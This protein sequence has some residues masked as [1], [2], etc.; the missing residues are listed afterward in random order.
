MKVRY[1]FATGL[2]AAGVVAAPLWNNAT[3]DDKPQ[4]DAAAEAKLDADK[5]KEE[6]KKYWLGIQLAATP[7]IL[8]RHVERLKDGGAMVAGVAPNS[9]AAKAGLQPGDHILKVNEAVVTSP[10][11]VVKVVHGSNGEAVVMRVLRGWEIDSYTV[12]PEIAPENPVIPQPGL[13][14]DAMMPPALNEGA[15]GARIRIFGPAQIVPPDVRLRM[16]DDDLPQNLLIRVEKKGD[17]PAKLH[18]ER[19]GQVWDVT[20]DDI[21]QLPE[22]LRPIAKR[23][24]AKNANGPVIFG[25]K[26]VPFSDLKD[27][28][29]EMQP[30][31]FAPGKVM[32]PPNVEMMQK[33]MQRQMQ[34]MQEMMKRMHQQMD[35]IQIQ[36]GQPPMEIGQPDEV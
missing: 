34:E 6:V 16:M 8:K 25:G 12:E 21:D 10:D 24:L 2:L 4:L 3:A 19:E 20:A 13:G 14:M 32:M 17:A 11:D 1:L 29:I 26:D 7:E 9:P 22:D 35:R 36:Q 18:I 31:H 30:G 33:Q 15:P 28:M 27:M 5:G 23:F